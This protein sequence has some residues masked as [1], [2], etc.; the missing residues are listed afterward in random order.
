MT[1]PPVHQS[2]QTK[3]WKDNNDVDCLDWT[4]Q[5]LDLNI[6]ENIWRLTK[7]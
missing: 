6:I 2:V 1:T 7:I 3:L 5:S 4:S